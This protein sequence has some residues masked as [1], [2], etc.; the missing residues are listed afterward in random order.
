MSRISVLLKPCA[1]VTMHPRHV[2]ITLL[3]NLKGLHTKP[4]DMSSAMHTLH[5]VAAFAL[6]DSHLAI[7]TISYVMFLLVFLEQFVFL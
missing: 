6:L 2:R 5:M 1:V 4:T 3:R 7:R